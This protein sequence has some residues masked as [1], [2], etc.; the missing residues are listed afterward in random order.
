MGGTPLAHGAYAFT[1]SDAEFVSGQILS[2]Q[3]RRREL[4]NQFSEA[5]LQVKLLHVLGS[6]NTP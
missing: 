5:D 3:T 4:R 1:Q 6:E 2:D